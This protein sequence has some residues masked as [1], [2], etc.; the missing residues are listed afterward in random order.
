MA[1]AYE[2]IVD[3]AAYERIALEDG[4]RLWELWDGVLVEKPGMSFEHNDALTE[5]VRQL[6]PQLD[7]ADF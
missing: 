7:R 5:L 4:D 2:Q 1:R 6:L 3:E